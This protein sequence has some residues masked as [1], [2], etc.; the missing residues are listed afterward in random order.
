MN[1]CDAAWKSSRGSLGPSRRMAQRRTPGQIPEPKSSEASSPL[2]LDTLHADMLP[3]HEQ[4][5]HEASGF[6]FDVSV[7]SLTSMTYR[8]WHR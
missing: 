1:C 4:R 2:P 7:T 3:V 5:G 6:R 8:I